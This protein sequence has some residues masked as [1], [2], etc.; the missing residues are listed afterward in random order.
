M[1]SEGCSDQFGGVYLDTSVSD[2]FLIQPDNATA[3]TAQVTAI[4][5]TTLNVAT[6]IEQLA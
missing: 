2:E 1:R 6:V 4:S 5:A 3:I